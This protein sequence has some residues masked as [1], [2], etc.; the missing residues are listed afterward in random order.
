MYKVFACALLFLFTLIF[1][2]I[3]V[4][5]GESD[6]VNRMFHVSLNSDYNHILLL[7]N[8]ELIVHFILA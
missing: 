7:R 4:L 3:H 8:L 5:Y 2:N 1:F 6:N